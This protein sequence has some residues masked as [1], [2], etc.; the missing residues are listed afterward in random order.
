MNQLVT[1]KREKT[2]AGLLETMEDN[3]DSGPKGMSIWGQKLSVDT[4][5]Q[6]LLRSD[7][8]SLLLVKDHMDPADL[9]SISSLKGNPGSFFAVRHATLSTN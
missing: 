1:V 3:P 4:I 9:L 2:V 8:K 6:I 5:Q 7:L